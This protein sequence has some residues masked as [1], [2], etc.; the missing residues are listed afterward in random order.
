MVANCPPQNR[1]NSLEGVENGA[2][3]DRARDL[4]LHLALNV[5]LV[6][7]VAVARIGAN[8][9]NGGIAVNAYALV[10]SLYL[11]VARIDLSRDDHETICGS[12]AE[13]CDRSYA[14]NRNLSISDG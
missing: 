13:L 9:L 6:T 4:Q 1:I 10:L 7:G 2:N 3:C 8:Q 11:I 12:C 5:A 14:A